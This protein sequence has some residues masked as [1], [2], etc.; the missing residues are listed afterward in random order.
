[1]ALVK[2]SKIGVATRKR[3]ALAQASAPAN[4][5]GSKRAVPTTAVSERI[6]AAS[7]ELA[8][9]ITEAAAAAEQLRRSMEQIAG[10]AEEASGAAE[11]QLAA[12]RRV[13]INLTTARGRA[14]DMRRRTEAVQIVLADSGAL[15]SASVRAIERSAE[16]Q[17]ASVAVITELERRAQEIANITRV[18]S[19]ISDQTNLL[20]LNAAIE[21]ARAGDHGRGFAVVAEE[22]RALAEGSEKSA[23][24]IQSLAGAIQDDVRTVRQAVRSAA[25]AAVAEAKT[26][27]DVAKGLDA[28]RAEMSVIA[29][30]SEE[31]ADSAIQAERAAAD[32]QRS[33]DL[34]ASAAEEQSSAAAESQTAIQQQASSLEQSQTAA[35]NLA[36]LAEKLRAG[37]AGSDAAEQIGASAEQLSAAVQE[38]SGAASEIMAA[39]DQ[40]SRGSQQQAAATQESSAA[41]AQIEKSA[42]LAKTNAT[43]VAARVDALAIALKDGGVSVTRLV[44]G[45]NTAVE[46]TRASLATIG[47]LETVGRNITKIVDGI[48]LMAV[49]T[50]MLAVSGSVEAARASDAGRG[51]ALVS[52]DIRALARETTSNAERVKDTV[53][54]ILDQIAMLRRDLEQII[55]SSEVE[56]QNNRSVTVALERLDVDVSQLG[57]A[58]MP[59]SR[60]EPMLFWP[61]RQKRRRGPARSRPRQKRPMPLLGRRQP[62]QRSR[63]VV[64]KTWRPRSK[65]SPPWRRT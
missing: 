45:V 39:I 33:A 36:R 21:A 62:P 7:E 54:D 64:P 29:R 9:G 41:L 53:I 50:T 8:G 23:Q 6:A 61:R 30:S 20:A 15:I 37:K 49:Q 3:P 44:E 42:T 48:A 17:T 31:I 56:V 27:I 38:L 22:V 25:E 13:Q 28:R 47:R 12:I 34:V 35:R 59:R 5:S 16:R 63:H 26:A 18:V 11:E 60:T 14:D 2:T 46:T 32:A 10:G 43:G 57:R 40:I 65:K 19:G 51:F 52:N 1:M 55:S 58:S 24:A 4:P